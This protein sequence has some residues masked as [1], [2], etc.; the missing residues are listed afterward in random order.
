MSRTIYSL[1]LLLAAT[2]SSY[3]QPTHTITDPEKKYKEAKEFFVKE[4]YALAYPIV[5]ELKQAYPENTI[6]DHTYI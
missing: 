4:Q 6:S 5:K 3:A 1:L 2:T